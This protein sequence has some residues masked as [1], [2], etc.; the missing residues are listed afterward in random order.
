M[1]C[2]RKAASPLRYFNSSSEVIRLVGMMYVKYPVSLRNV[3]D[4]M[5]EREKLTK[6]FVVISIRDFRLIQGVVLII[7]MPNFFAQRFDLFF[8]F[9]CFGSSLCHVAKLRIRR[10]KCQ[11]YS[12]IGSRLKTPAQGPGS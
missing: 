7:V 8:A 2:P 10:A 4:L 5:F 6:Q 1:P 12:F 11:V 9:R 3:E